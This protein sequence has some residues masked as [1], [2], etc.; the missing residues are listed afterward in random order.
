MRHWQ[1]LRCDTL[2][3]ATLP[4]CGLVKGDCSTVTWD[5]MDRK[6]AP[7]F[8]SVAASPEVQF[9]HNMVADGNVDEVLSST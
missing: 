2:E 8:D 4:L 3:L 9:V 1:I 6:V 7:F 5:S